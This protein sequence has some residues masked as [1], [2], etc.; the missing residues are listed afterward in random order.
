MGCQVSIL[1]DGES[2]MSCSLYDSKNKRINQWGCQLKPHERKSFPGEPLP[3]NQQHRYKC[4]LTDRK[5]QKLKDITVDFFAFPLNHEIDLQTDEL[6]NGKWIRNLELSHLCS[7]ILPGIRIQDRECYGKVYGNCFVANELVTYL[8]LHRVAQNVDHAVVMCQRL[9]DYNIFSKVVEGHKFSNG[10][11]FFR[12]NTKH[13]LVN[14]KGKVTKSLDVWDDD[15]AS[16][17]FHVYHSHNRVVAPRIAAIRAYEGWLEK[18]TSLGFWKMRFFRILPSDTG[19]FGSSIFFFEDSVSKQA[20]GEIDSS[21]VVTV[22]RQGKRNQ[23]NVIVLTTE[24]DTKSKKTAHF[25]RTPNTLSCDR[26]L[27][28]LQTF[29]I[30]W[31]AVDVVCRSVLALVFNFKMCQ[32]FAK[33]LKLVTVKKNQRIEKQ[34]ALQ[35]KFCILKSGTIG[36]FTRS[37]EGKYTKYGLQTPMSHFGEDYLLGFKPKSP[38]SL[39]VRMR[40]RAASVNSGR[41]SSIKS[42][43]SAFQSGVSDIGSEGTAPSVTSSKS[44]RLSFFGSMGLMSSRARH[45]VPSK[46]YAPKVKLSI[47][48][49]TSPRARAKDSNNTSLASSGRGSPSPTAAAAANSPGSGGGGGGGGGGSSVASPATAVSPFSFPGP[50][51]LDSG[52]NSRYQDRVTRVVIE[53]CEILTMSMKDIDYFCSKYK[54]IRGKLHILLSKEI[55]RCIENVPLLSHLSPAQLKRLTLGLHFHT[56]EEGDVLFY[57]G[58]P[59]HCFYIVFNGALDVVQYSSQLNKEIKLRE[60]K[61]SDSFGEISLLLPGVPRTDTVR[62]KSRSLLL[63]LDQE[64]FEAFREITDFNMETIMRKNII[65]TLTQFRIPFIKDIGEEKLSGL[66]RIETFHKDEVIF[67]RGEEATKFYI[68]YYGEVHV[69]RDGKVFKHLIQGD[70]CGEVGILD[71]HKQRTASCTAVK[72]TVVLSINK[73]QFGKLF[74][75]L[76]EAR[77]EMEIRILGKNCHLRS[78]LYHKIGFKL[79]KKFLKERSAVENI[80]FWSDVREFRKRYTDGKQNKQAMNKLAFDIMMQYIQADAETPVNL[81]GHMLTNIQSILAK[82]ECHS[83]MFSDAEKEIIRLMQSDKLGRF[84]K[85]KYFAKLLQDVR[86][87]SMSPRV[88]RR[89]IRKIR[90]GSTAAGFWTSAGSAQRM[91][92]SQDSVETQLTHKHTPQPVTTG[93]SIFWNFWNVS[94]M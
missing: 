25:V 4:M 3:I 35:N 37:S 17:S 63:S 72:R 86:S 43:T 6:C 8:I 75:D 73:E 83:L 33:K 11:L 27:R 20:K 19:R 71:D 30:K 94:L 42:G 29:T 49:S 85:S 10:F 1:N 46:K 2:M 59:G 47:K 89:N 14:L 24:N 76:P 69:S 5:G 12:L 31:S 36:I 80:L 64:T 91:A 28:A 26:W 51:E 15:L 45:S 60:L 88:R 58:D 13:P 87:Y 66:C 92:L 90:G 67:R 21:K 41:P 68:V 32:S 93:C 70:Y 38:H 18:K 54:G 61:P 78:I 52:C 53:D 34:A 50:A 48:V 55:D 84:K 77:S 39:S 81:P 7:E 23:T 56:V 62:A 44:G 65:N 9:V 79:F 82:N 57:E 22:A 16:Y 74:A 40:Q